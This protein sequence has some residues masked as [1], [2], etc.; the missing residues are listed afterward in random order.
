M[1]H[2]NKHKKPRPTKDYTK[3]KFTIKKT[4][5]DIGKLSPLDGFHLSEYIRVNLAKTSD[6]IEVGDGSDDQNIALFFKSVLGLDPL[7]VDYIRTTLFERIEFENKEQEQKGFAPLA[8]LENMAFEN[9]EVI[10][11]YEVLVRALYVNFSGSFTEILL[12]FE[13]VAKFLKQRSSKTSAQS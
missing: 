2:E 6:S 12:V 5:F 3:P 4:N 8:G 9:F 1:K 10:N 7:V 13:G 11:I